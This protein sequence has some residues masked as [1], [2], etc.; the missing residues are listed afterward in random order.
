MCGICGEI[1]WDGRSA[2]VAAV[3]RMTG[4]MVGRTPVFAH[5][6]PRLPQDVIP[7]DTVEKGVETPTLRLLG[8]SP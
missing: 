5:P 1:R 7:A 6:L 3:T 2:D 8:R 4:A